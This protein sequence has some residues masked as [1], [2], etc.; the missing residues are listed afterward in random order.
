M[1]QI[2][3]GADG[4]A[5]GRID[6]G[7]VLDLAELEGFHAQDDLGEVGALDFRHGELVPLLKILLR[8]KADADAVLHAAGAAVC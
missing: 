5:D 2:V 8:V 7:E 4:G 1:Q 6:E 3:T